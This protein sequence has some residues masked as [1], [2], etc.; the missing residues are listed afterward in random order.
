VFAIWVLLWGLTFGVIEKAISFAGLITLAFVVCAFK[1]HPPAADLL[2]GAIP[3][4]PSHHLANYWYVAVSIIGATL[5]PF[6]LFFYSSGV[7]EEKWNA[8][9]LGVNRAVAGLGMG[10]GSIITLSILVVSAQ[11]LGPHGIRIDEYPQAAGM[12]TPVFRSWGLA[13][14]ALSLAIASLGAAVEVS[15]STAYEIAQ[16]LG[17]NWGKQKKA[18]DEAR[19]TVSYSAMLVVAAIPSV[20]GIDPLSLTAFTMAAACLALPLVTV[21]FLVLMNDRLYLGR[22]TNRRWANFVVAGIVV[23]AFVLAIVAIPLQVAGG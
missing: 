4:F 19:F 18:R 17:W 20:A 6:M 13:L 15:L 22:H 1:L 12:L 10:F 8:S 7:I 11:V 16:T 2:A 23:I 14:F 9:Y 5:T 21:P 3:S